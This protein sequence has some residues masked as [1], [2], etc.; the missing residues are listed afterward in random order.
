MTSDGFSLTGRNRTWHEDDVPLRVSHHAFAQFD[1]H[2]DNQLS[3]LVRS[4]AHTAAPNA[5]RSLRG[6]GRGAELP[7]VQD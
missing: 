7:T 4:W 6:Q 5:Q 2:L 1:R 3:R